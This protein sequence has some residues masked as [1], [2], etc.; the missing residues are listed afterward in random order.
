MLSER[1]KKLRKR[2]FNTEVRVAEGRYLSESDIVPNAM[3]RAKRVTFDGR[4]L[5]EDNGQDDD[6]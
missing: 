3:K 5:G 4:E 1:P 2:L 6:L